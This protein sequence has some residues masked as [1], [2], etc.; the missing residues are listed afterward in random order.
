MKKIRI[1]LMALFAVLA[2]GM[3]FTGFSEPG[4]FP[5]SEYY[6]CTFHG[7]AETKFGIVLLNNPLRCLNVPGWAGAEADHESRTSH[8]ASDCIQLNGPND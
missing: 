3:S 1:S 5:S 6:D 4:P 8:V 7:D 2:V